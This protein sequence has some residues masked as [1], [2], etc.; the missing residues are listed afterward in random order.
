MN[1]HTVPRKLLEQ[2]AYDDPKTKQKRLWRYEKGRTPY[3]KASPHTAT[4]I[5]RHFADPRNASKEAE[6]EHRL[7][8]EFEQP[9]NEY[10]SQIGYRTFPWSTK[11]FRQL[12]AYVTLLFYRSLARKMATV[13]QVEV[14]VKTLRGLLAK[15]DKLT[16]LAVRWVESIEEVTRLLEK[17]I[18]DYLAPDQLEHS[19]A[20]TVERAMSRTH[21]ELLN[22]QWR[23]VNAEPGNPFV[24]GDAPVVTWRRDTRGT[25]HNGFGFAEP[26][27]EAFLPVSPVA[28]LHMLPAVSRSRRVITPTTEEINCAQA[29]YASRQCFTNLYSASLDVLL[30]PRFN[31]TKLGITGFSIRH[32]NYED[33]MF[34]IL[35]N[36]GR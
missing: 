3:R 30:Q 29:S 20:R 24:I 15:E 5:D 35:M 33:Q 22:G 16:K 2:F 34:E 10:I 31:E 17:M 13:Q 21:D 9:V 8:V 28:S 12:S 26:D 19:Y 27:V 25:P 36:R 6:L 32:R 14:A 1:S 7:N 23:V 4:V 18:E 11:H